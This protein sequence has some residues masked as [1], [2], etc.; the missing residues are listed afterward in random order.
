M[1]AIKEFN[2]WLAI[3]LKNNQFFSIKNP[4]DLI[5]FDFLENIGENEDFDI[6]P[7][8]LKKYNFLHFNGS[9]KI[10]KINNHNKVFGIIDYTHKVQYGK[11]DKNRFLTTFRPLSFSS[12]A[13]IIRS[14]NRL[15]YNVYAIGEIT[16]EKLNDSIILKCDEVLGQVS[17]KA[18]DIMSPFNAMDCIPKKWRKP[19]APNTMEYPGIIDLKNKNV[20]SIDG[21]STIDV[22]DAVHYDFQNNLHI[23]GIHI[24]DVANLFFSMGQDK[25]EFLHLIQQ[26]CSSIYPDGKIDMI[27]REVGENICSLIEGTEKN[28]VSLLLEFQQEKPYAMVSAK[29]HLSRIINKNK[30]TYRNVDKILNGKSGKKEISKDIYMIK[31]IIDSQKNLPQ[32][33]EEDVEEKYQDEK[34]SRT[35]ICKLM[36]IYNTIIAKKLYDTHKK[37]IVRVHYGFSSVVDVE[38]DEVRDVMQRMETF[39]GYYRVAE[40]TPEDEL[41]HSGLGLTYYTHATSPIRRFVDFWNQICLYETLYGGLNATGMLNI[42]ERIGEINWRQMRIKKAYE[43]LQ[44]VHIYHGKINGELEESYE[45]YVIGIEEENLQIYLPGMNGKVFRFQVDMERME[46][47]LE[48]QFP[49]ENEIYWKRKDNGN[50]FSIQK[51]QKIT[52]KIIIHKHRY[53]WVQKIGIELIEPSFSSFLLN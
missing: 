18:L 51:F 10:K 14:K 4:G 45:G 50:I 34:I 2:D 20:F 40:M 37:S 29:I 25:Y 47:L 43:M 42:V 22:D 53:N 3:D 7:K 8:I 39:K 24:A 32:I 15:N 26:N 21:D 27:S 12:P 38:N 13:M 33:S 1:F 28:V 9:I 52:C 19:I 17:T 48:M 46:N 5:P 30:L 16:N 41:Q 31:E 35:L 6:D 23:I 36:T 49:N 11:D 44:L